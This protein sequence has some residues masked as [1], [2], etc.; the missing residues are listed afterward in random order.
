MIDSKKEKLR[1]VIGT[2]FV[3]GFL[4]LAGGVSEAIPL[5]SCTTISS[6]GEYVLTADL[7]SS[8]DTCINIT[9]SDVTFDGHGHT[10][11][12]SYR[13]RAYGVF[14]YNPKATLT[15]VVVKRLVA[16]EWGYGIYYKNTEDGVIDNN[17]VL[18]NFFGITLASSTNSNL[19]NNNV[20][21]NKHIGINLSSSSDHN[22]I[23]Q[24]DITLNGNG[25]VLFHSS[26][27]SIT[28]NTLDT[29]IVNGIVLSFSTSNTVASNNITNNKRGITVHSS[30]SNTI[31]NN[32]FKNTDNVFSLDSS[33][34]NSWS[35]KMAPGPN[36]VGGPYMGGNLWTDPEGHRFS[37][38]CADYDKNGICD[39]AYVIDP[40]NIDNLPL[41]TKESLDTAFKIPSEESESKVTFHGMEVKLFFYFLLLPLLG[42]AIPLLW[43]RNSY[44]E[45]IR[46]P[47]L[48][49]KL[50]EPMAIVAGPYS[51]KKVKE[52]LGAW[53][54][55]FKGLSACIFIY[56]LV[57]FVLF[58]GRLDG[59]TGP[60]EA[61]DAVVSS[62]GMAL[63]LA[64]LGA[65][66]G[67]G[68]VINDAVRGLIT[69]METATWYFIFAALAEGIALYGLVIMFLILNKLGRVTAV[70]AASLSGPATVFG[71]LALLSGV[72]VG[73]LPSRVSVS[74][75]GYEGW[76]TKFIAAAIGLSVAL[77]GL[78]Y[79]FLG[80]GKI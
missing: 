19:V 14:V 23:S 7:R 48:R 62:A 52:G 43:L 76:T 53:L 6:P 79:A 63:G 78:I 28:S 13:W 69:R 61:A 2:G 44:D 72:L 26:D 24:N 57:G 9:A 55:I 46:D 60:M 80:L 37:D 15:N 22:T 32:Y 31:Y 5:L 30:K 11:R 21:G 17:T 65:G 20:S 3:L 67:I 29:N 75:N 10:I 68:L 38:N 40:E 49:M 41:N 77:T 25:I 16:T 58:K 18:T 50:E 54:N 39:S 35:I 47:A 33:L 4:I 74:A 42:A 71:V 45:A 73:Y 36:I 66:I 27:N 56:G 1:I 70:D 51:G 34:R 8:E 12:G 59:Y 64:C